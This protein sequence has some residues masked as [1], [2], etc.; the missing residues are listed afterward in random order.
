MNGRGGAQQTR[1]QGRVFAH[2][3]SAN[4]G[5]QATLAAP[6]KADGSLGV[7]SGVPTMDGHG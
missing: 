3:G 6:N 7:A 5:H 1:R 4:H 2:E